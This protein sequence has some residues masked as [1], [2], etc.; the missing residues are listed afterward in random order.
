M[1]GLEV[2]EELKRMP[3]EERSKVIEYARYAEKEQLSQ[4]ELEGVLQKMVDASDPAT[5]AKLKAE[6][7]RGV[8]GNEPHA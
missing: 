6:F 4:E 7:M 1:T 3:R 2:I 5:K 8:Y